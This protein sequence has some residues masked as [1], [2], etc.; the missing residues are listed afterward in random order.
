MSAYSGAYWQREYS[1][2]VLAHNDGRLLDRWT[3]LASSVRTEVQSGIVSRQRRRNSV[4]WDGIED[5]DPSDV[6]DGRPIRRVGRDQ[7]DRNARH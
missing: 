7:V 1:R 6:L 2:M 5:A 3:N 4:R